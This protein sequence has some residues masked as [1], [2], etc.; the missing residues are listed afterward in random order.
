MITRELAEKLAGNFKML[1]RYPK[2]DDALVDA[3]MAAESEEA[4]QRFV[5]LWIRE[6]PVCPMPCDIYGALERPSRQ[7][8]AKFFPPIPAGEEALPAEYFCD[9]CEDSGWIV[10]EGSKRIPDAPHLHYTGAR[11]C[12]HPPDA[13]GVRA[14]RGDKRH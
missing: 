3:F 14:L 13:R 5:R 9:L 10:Q 1:R 12:V 6:S 11:R 4:A 8:F 2:Q 7:D